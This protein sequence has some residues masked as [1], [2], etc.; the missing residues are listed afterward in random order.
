[1]NIYMSYNLF[2]LKILNWSYY[3]SAKQIKNNLLV[4]SGFF[5]KNEISYNASWNKWKYFIVLSPKFYQP[6]HNKFIKKYKYS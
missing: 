4:Y 2:I 5:S 6:T 1:M 3:Y